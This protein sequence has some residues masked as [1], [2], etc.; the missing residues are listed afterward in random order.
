MARFPSLNKL[1]Q[2]SARLLLDRFDFSDPIW[3]TKGRVDLIVTSDSKKCRIEIKFISKLD[4]NRNRL[5]DAIRKTKSN[6]ATKKLDFLL[7]TTLAKKFSKQ[8]DFK[9][10][11]GYCVLGILVSK[12]EIEETPPEILANEILNK[13]RDRLEIWDE[14]T[15]MYQ[16]QLLQHSKDIE[17]LSE[18]NQDQTK[19]IN[20]VEGKVDSLENKVGSL[21]S[22]VDSLENK[23]DSL[24]NKVENKVDS[25]E[26]KVDSL[27]NK[28]DSLE[29]KVENKVDS[30]ENKVEALR[31]DV[32]DNVEDIRN[33]LGNLHD[34]VDNVLSILIEFVKKKNGNE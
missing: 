17:K 30:L 1:S 12:V 16:E 6:I 5:I 27:E 19:H 7:V 8:E 3:E 32:D 21:E 31:N 34:K 23:V 10:V 22:K 18:L 11:E 2:E 4:E 9:R 28:V 24:E 15:S 13:A 33:D 26:T 20:A 29:N 25:L 14:F